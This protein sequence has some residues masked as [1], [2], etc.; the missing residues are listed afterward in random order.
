MRAKSKVKSFSEERERYLGA[1]TRIE[2]FG[3]A[4]SVVFGSIFNCAFGA[5]FGGLPLF[6]MLIPILKGNSN[7]EGDFKWLPV[8]FILPFIGVGAGL[9]ISGLV[10]LVR[11]ILLIKNAPPVTAVPVEATSTYEPPSPSLKETFGKVSSTVRDF[12]RGKL[13][14]P[15]EEESERPKM[16]G[17]QRLVSAVFGAIFLAIGCG[18]I[19]WG[20]FNY[21]KCYRAA[22]TWVSVP[23]EIVSAKI[24][25]NHG[26]KGGTSYS[27]EITFR[28][29]YGGETFSSDEISL[30]P[31]SS[32]KN[33]ASA[34]QEL[35]RLRK[36]KN[37]WVD[38]E[39]PSEAALE[40]PEAAF[41]FEKI[42]LPI[43][44][45]PFALM[46]G[47]VFGAAIFGGRER[48]N[49]RE[50]E[51]DV[52]LPEADS[53]FGT[54]FF[55]LGWNSFVALFLVILLAKDEIEWI[56]VFF[57]IPFSLIGLI[58]F[59]VAIRALMKHFSGFS[60]TLSLRPSK[61]LVAGEPVRVLW[62]LTCGEAEKLARL[63]LSFV[64]MERDEDTEVN[65]KPVFKIVER[66]TI[67]ESGARIDL[68]DGACDF[69]PPEDKGSSNRKRRFA[70][71]LELERKTGLL[72]KIVLRFPVKLK[73]KRPSEEES[74]PEA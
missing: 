54:V 11:L 73:A 19:T 47:F 20:V 38:P 1:R 74:V 52:V 5:V 9:L 32:F 71:E 55:A 36:H 15:G 7:V 10:K 14:V 60:Y 57:L 33:H 30:Q 67:C 4:A 39:A 2:R 51:R 16:S 46:G 27:P 63:S 64:L 42:I 61:N 53:P 26:R 59:V 58:V 6:F 69:T 31:R 8:L 24:D 17:K 18:I 72:G 44:G 40:K 62:K 56:L 23:C 45:L 41:S 12:R 28:Y 48:K 50:P 21:V 29:T 13:V 65:G 68:R 37:C 22:E 43:F 25:T 35:H 66:T 3:I 49:G 70:F 34:K